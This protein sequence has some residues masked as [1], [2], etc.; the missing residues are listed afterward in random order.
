MTSEPASPLTV[1][2][3]QGAT[4]WH[5]AAA[6]R[7][8]Y[9]ALVRSLRGRRPGRA[10]GNLPSPASATTPAAMPRTWTAKAWRGCVRWPPRSMRSI[11]GSLAIREGE[12]VLQPP[13]LGAAR[14]AASPSTTSAICSAWPASTTRYGGGSERLI[15]ELK[16]WRICRRSATTCV[17]RSGCA[18]AAAIGDAERLDYDLLL[19]VANWPAPR[20]HAWRPCCARG[21]SRT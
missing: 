21:R 16:G 2:L 20:R 19:F 5:D 10:A 7:D 13:V 12:N 4:R 11:T 9:G 3:V 14:T 17:F 6:N 1:S 15:V 18:I 8:Y